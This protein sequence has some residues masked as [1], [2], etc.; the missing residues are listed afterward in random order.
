MSRIPKIGAAPGEAGKTEFLKPAARQPVQNKAFGIKRQAETKDAAVEKKQKIAFGGVLKRNALGT[1]QPS[2]ERSVPFS[3]RTK[4]V[5]LQPLADPVLVRGSMPAMS[6][7]ALVPK[8]APKPKRPAWDLK[9]RVQDLDE[10]IQKVQQRNASLE[11]NLEETNGRIASLEAEKCRLNE[12]VVIKS[13]Q[14]EEASCQIQRLT[15][16]L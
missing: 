13:A 4:R 9:G 6:I 10:V 1:I 11:K 8:V 16:S 3:N 5:A 15:E 12:N 14:T 2:Q 7:A